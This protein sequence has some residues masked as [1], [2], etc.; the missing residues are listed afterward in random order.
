MNIKTTM[1]LIVISLF[2]ALPGSGFGKERPSDVY[3]SLAVTDN[4]RNHYGENLLYLDFQDQVDT[5]ELADRIV[6]SP[7][8]KSGS[9]RLDGKMDE[10]NPTYLTTVRGRVMNNYPLGKYFDAVP[11]KIQIGSAFDEEFVYFV[12]HFEDSSHTAST[13]RGRWVY[14]GKEWEPMAHVRPAGNTPAANAANVK[15][16][17]RGRESEDRVYLMFPVVDRQRN[18][19]ADGLGCAMYCHANL[20]HSG[21]PKTKL[22][23]EGV[24]GMHT[25]VKGDL[26]DVWR[27]QS[28]RTR[29]M[30]SAEDGHLSYGVG[31]GFHGI[32]PDRGRSATLENNA[33]T[34]LAAKKA[35]PVFVNTLDLL[36]G[37]YRK[38]GFA[39]KTLNM[40]MMT[41]ITGNLKFSK[42]VSI[43]GVMH[44]IPTGSQSDVAAVSHYDPKTN[45]WTVEFRRALNTGDAKDRQFVTGHDAQHPNNPIAVIGDA[46]RG[47]TLYENNGC[48]TCHGKVGQGV[49][50]GD[51]WL[52]PRI[53][54]ASGALIIKT[55]KFNQVMRG[56]VATLVSAELQRKTEIIMPDIDV[57]EQ[58]AEDIATWLQKQM[59]PEKKKKRKKK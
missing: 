21:D 39:T 24:A 38:E 3:F 46:E 50:A 58:E 44:R 29:A 6:I 27:W 15:E 9:I 18:F 20:K 54:R 56:R 42:G 2:L 47:E 55:V 34:L 59:P 23:G 53:Q 48:I 52:F 40:E 17:A 4:S 7:R 16:A 51:K 33:V 30:D 13:N 8:V 22:I 25:I 35:S 36:A 19:R 43:P 12:V 1:I 31:V 28:T 45:H 11:N 41:P 14:N 26:A 37:N 57:S 49:F 5:D 10:W 32:L